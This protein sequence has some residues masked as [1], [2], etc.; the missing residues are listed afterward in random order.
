MNLYGISI[1]HPRLAIILFAT[2]TIFSIIGSISESENRTIKSSRAKS[3]YEF[4]KKVNREFGPDGSEILLLINHEEQ[5]G[6]LFDEGT[7]ESY[8]KLLKRIKKI[9]SV[10][11]VFSFDQIPTFGMGLIKLPLFPEKGASLSQRNA[12]RK[13]ALNHPLVEGHLLSSDARTSLVPLRL[14]LKK[15]KN[16]LINKRSSRSAL[17]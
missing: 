7:S 16:K 1:Q 10:S 15:N 9:P 6:D 3:D 14:N 12:C 8:K 13:R 11:E 5:N 2:I 4:T 17:S